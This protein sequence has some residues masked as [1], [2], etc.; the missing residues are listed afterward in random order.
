MRQ[1][2]VR[3]LPLM[4]VSENPKKSRLGKLGCL[5]SIEVPTPDYSHI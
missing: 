2:W 4:G 5:P 1:L 3:N